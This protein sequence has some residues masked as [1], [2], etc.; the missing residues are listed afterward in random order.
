M[1]ALSE[2]VE[3]LCIITINLIADTA[4]RE[5]L[6]TIHHLLLFTYSLPHKIKT[7]FGYSLSAYSSGRV[8]IVDGLAHCVELAQELLRM[9]AVRTPQLG[10]DVLLESDYL[11]PDVRA[12]T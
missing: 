12:L 6:S 10:V 5:M 2:K 7:C 3:F 11:L 4:V 8:E 1:P 9:L